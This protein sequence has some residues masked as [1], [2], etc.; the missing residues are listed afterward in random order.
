MSGTRVNDVRPVVHFTRGA[1]RF[2][3]H[4]DRS[5]RGVTYVG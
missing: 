2:E 1:H 5:E 3:V 4:R